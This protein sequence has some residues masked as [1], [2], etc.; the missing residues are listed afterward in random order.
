MALADF[1]IVAPLT[2]PIQGCSLNLLSFPSGVD[3][4]AHALDRKNWAG[5]KAETPNKINA[6]KGNRFNML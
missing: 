5:A 4:E 1:V 6:A 3:T 2:A